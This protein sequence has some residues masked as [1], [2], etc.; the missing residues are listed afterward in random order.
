[1]CVPTLSLCVYVQLVDPRFTS[2]RLLV[3]VSVGGGGWRRALTLQQ[4]PGCARGVAGVAEE[5]IVP[6]SAVNGGGHDLY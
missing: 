5:A 4:L 6:P 2:L 1:M 3:W